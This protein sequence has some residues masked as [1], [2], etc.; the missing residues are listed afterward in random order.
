MVASRQVEIP[1]YRAVGRQRGQGFGS[2]AQAIRRTAIS[3]LCKDILPAAKGVVADVLEFS[4]P[5]LADF[6][7]IRKTFNKAAK[8]VERKTEKTNG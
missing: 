1:F 5:E 2:L 8:S 4:V 7:I 6:F 3:F